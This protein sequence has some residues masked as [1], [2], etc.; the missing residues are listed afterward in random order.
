MRAA[1]PG[2]SIA[3]LSTSRA[4]AALGLSLRMRP[5]Y[6]P[7]RAFNRPALIGGGRLGAAEANGLWLHRD[8]AELLHE[9]ELVDAV[10]VLDDLS[11]PHPHDV[12]EL[13]S[14]GF[15]CRR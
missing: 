8:H 10:P 13:E 9:A 11:V 6:P 4:F 7:P 5:R 2:T 14:D 1:T 3:T 15:A 12:D